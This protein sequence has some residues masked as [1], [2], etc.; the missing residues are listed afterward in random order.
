[1]FDA[2]LPFD[3]KEKVMCILSKA[4]QTIKI[5]L[6]NCKLILLQFFLMPL[7]TDSENY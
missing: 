2:K 4:Q 5:D 6:P 1:M 3:C 7:I